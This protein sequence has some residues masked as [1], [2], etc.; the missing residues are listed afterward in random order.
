MPFFSVTVTPDSGVPSWSRI[1]CP[2]RKEL[3][4]KVRMLSRLGERRKTKLLEAAS[5]GDLETVD[6]LLAKGLSVNT[7]D[8]HGMT[9]LMYAA[10]AGSYGVVRYLLKRGADAN[11]RNSNGSTALMLAAL[12]GHTITIRVLLP[13]ADI[14]MRDVDGRTAVMY[15]ASHGNLTTVELLIAHGAEVTGSGSERPG[16]SK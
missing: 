10:A 9:P 14:N 4:I 11:A 15:A 12:D 3:T 2:Y 5:R 16:A 13:Y 6:R 8:K 1:V 7:R